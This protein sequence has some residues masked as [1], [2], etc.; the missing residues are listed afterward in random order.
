MPW[1]AFSPDQAVLYKYPKSSQE[2]HVQILQ[3]SDKMQG[4]TPSS[5]S[6]VPNHKESGLMHDVCEVVGERNPS[7]LAD[8]SNTLEDCYANSNAPMTPTTPGASDVHR[9]ANPGDLSGAYRKSGDNHVRRRGRRKRTTKLP[10]KGSVQ[11]KPVHPADKGRLR[12]CTSEETCQFCR[13]RGIPCIRGESHI[14]PRRSAARENKED[15]SHHRLETAWG[16]EPDQCKEPAMVPAASSP[17]RMH[18]GI[19]KADETVLSPADDT[20]VVYLNPLLPLAHPQPKQQSYGSLERLE[21][22]ATL[23]AMSMDIPDYT[24][25]IA[26]LQSTHEWES[27]QMIW[28]N[29]ISV[30]TP[31][32]DR[33]APPGWNEGWPGT[34]N[35]Q[36]ER[37]DADVSGISTEDVDWLFCNMTGNG[38]HWD[39]WD[40]MADH[41]GMNA[42]PVWPSTDIPQYALDDMGTSV[43][44]PHYTLPG[45]QVF[46]V[47]TDT[48][49]SLMDP[50]R[51]PPTEYVDRW[52]SAEANPGHWEAGGTGSQ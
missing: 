31:G 51:W 10:G 36:E 12:Q 43:S 29:N 11:S 5:A 4:S 49:D 41:E 1:I 30:D 24:P 23:G 17:P 14:S 40:G 6:P 15:P 3:F 7:S 50:V 16:T 32:P 47:G 20:R 19:E 39:A 2:L 48:D 37:G 28:P 25:E 45:G 52:Q 9:A 42:L 8:A 13:T 27:S 26:S 18:L 44:W 22:A 33:V 35:N 38:A 21:A 34:M 46:S